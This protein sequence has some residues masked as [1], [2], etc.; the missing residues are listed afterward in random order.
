MALLAI[1]S[2]FR[3]YKMADQLPVDSILWSTCSRPWPSER[4]HMRSLNVA[5]KP[6]NH[7]PQRVA[8][9]RQ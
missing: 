4:L 3:A 7:R 6:C 8:I 5:Q 9:E 2:Q 1:G